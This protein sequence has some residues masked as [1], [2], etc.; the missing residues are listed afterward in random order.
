LQC[1]EILNADRKEKIIGF[2]NIAII[3]NQMKSHVKIMGSS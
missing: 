3:E 2:S 1:H